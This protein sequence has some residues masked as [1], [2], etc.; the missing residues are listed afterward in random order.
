MSNIVAAT[1]ATGEKTA[2]TRQLYQWDYGM[3]LQFEGVELPDS[4]V[5]HFANNALKGE[6][7]TQ[8]GGENGVD[9]PDEYLATGQ[10]VYAWIMLHTGSS[11]GQTE[12]MVTIP[13]QKRP[14]PTEDE[15]TPVQRGLIET[16]LEQLSAGVAAVDAAME[17]IAQIEVDGHAIVINHGTE[18]D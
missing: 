15:P 10:P 4:Y 13:V 17:T 6:A 12:Y 11:D 1:F 16:A 5:V 7:K 8:I 14:R 3:V 2:E 9:I 18:G